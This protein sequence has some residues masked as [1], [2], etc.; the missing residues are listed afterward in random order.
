MLKYS[1]SYAIIKSTFEM[2]NL[3][4]QYHIPPKMNLTWFFVGT[5]PVCSIDLYFGLVNRKRRFLI[6]VYFRCPTESID[7]TTTRITLL[8]KKQ[9]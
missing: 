8:G 9:S 5:I 3:C 7:K 1:L 2:T 6:K 4:L